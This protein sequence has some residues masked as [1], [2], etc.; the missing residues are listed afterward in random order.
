MSKEYFNRMAAQWDETVAE[1]D[2]V[3]LERLVK[4]LDITEGSTILDV[5]TGTGVFVPFLLAK[6]GET[7]RLVALDFAEV[8]LEK[9]KAKGF[10]GNIEYLNADIATVPL[11]N[12]IFNAVICYSSFPHFHDKPQALREINRLLMNGGKLFIC[13]TSSRA[14]INEIH[15]QIATVADDIIPDADEMHNMLSAAGFADINIMDSADSYLAS[16]SKRK[17]TK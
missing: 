5:G 9:A 16:A 7:G 8:M 3:K 4:R 15:S 1:K 14:K 2:S 11:P 6:I 12:G 13:H 17:R 10:K